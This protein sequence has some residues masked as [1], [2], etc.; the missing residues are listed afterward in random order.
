[1]PRGGKREGAGRKPG[2]RSA[3][4]IEQ[5]AT[6]SD[7]AK[8]H[9]VSA[10]NALAQIATAGESESARVS[11]ANALLDRGFGKPV[12]SM[13]HTSPDGTM[14]PKPAIDATKLSSEAMAEI[15]NAATDES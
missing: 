3:A 15:L 11:A 4:T 12:Q 9:A 7:L 14:T 5:Q 1:M 10:I 8:E 6:I 2:S 13:E